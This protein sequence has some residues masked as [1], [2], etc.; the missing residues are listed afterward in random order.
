MAA[1]TET[2]KVNKIN[3]RKSKRDIERELRIEEKGGIPI[4]VFYGI[5]LSNG[6]R[7]DRI[8]LDIK[9]RYSYLDTEIKQKGIV[10][11]KSYKN[12]GPDRTT[13][14]FIA[15]IVRS[16]KTRA[17]KCGVAFDLKI[18]DLVI[19]ETCPVFGIKLVIGNKIANDT[20]S[21]DRL[22]PELG[23]VMDNVAFVSMKANRLKSNATLQE[24]ETLVE[25]MRSK[26]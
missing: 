8:A 11:K 16:A 6:V 20:P 4:E 26:V 22:V 1:T 15:A 17:E 18:E 12:K 14:Q 24:L 25:W 21:L 7:N 3:N 2:A 5:P 10:K 23:Y 9:L 13:R 19:P